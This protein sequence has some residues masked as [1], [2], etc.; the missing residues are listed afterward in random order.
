[1]F[2]REGDH[3]YPHIHSYL[4]L[5]PLGMFCVRRRDVCLSVLLHLILEGGGGCFRVCTFVSLHNNRIYGRGHEEDMRRDAAPCLKVIVSSKSESLCVWL[6]LYESTY[7]RTR[8][9]K[10]T[11]ESCHSR[12]MSPSP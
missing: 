4:I 8:A 10:H 6:W 12:C 11:E 7:L 1:M 9:R 3:S 2:D 5:L